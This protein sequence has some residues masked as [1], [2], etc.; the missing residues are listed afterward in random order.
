MAR[1]SPSQLISRAKLLV[2]IFLIDTANSAW[3]NL[4]FG[5]YFE[6]QAGV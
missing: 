3:K 6:S 5:R 4:D 2:D 1:L